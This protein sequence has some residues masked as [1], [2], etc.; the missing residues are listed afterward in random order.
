MRT[1]QRFTRLLRHVVLLGTSGERGIA[2]AK[3]VDRLGCSR[4]TVYRDKHFLRACGLAVRDEKVNGEVWHRLPVEAVAGWMLPAHVGAGD[5]QLARLDAWLR[6]NAPAAAALLPTHDVRLTRAKQRLPVEVLAAVES[7]LAAG[8]RLRLHYQDAGG[9]TTSRLVD[10]AALREHD[11]QLY[12]FAADVAKQAP[13]RFKLARAIAAEPTGD[14]ADLAHLAATDDDASIG[15]WSAPPVDVRL[16]LAPSAV[17]LAREHPLPHQR[18][19][20]QP[21]GSAELAATVAGEVEI[22]AWVLG[23]G[24]SVQVLAPESLR[25]AV[26]AELS[27]ALAYYADTQGAAP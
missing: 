1:V 23:F 25:T 9:H 22:R 20:K 15:I 4:A 2:T 13:R 8:R 14:A 7:A 16:W 3:L 19:V 5:D 10:P 26:A 11:G 17:K 21:D 24:A 27:Q 6:Q 12:L 18:L